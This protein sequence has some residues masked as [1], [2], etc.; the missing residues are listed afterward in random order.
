MRFL[1]RNVFSMHGKT[2]AEWFTPEKLASEEDIK[3]LTHDLQLV[4]EPFLL[5]RE[6]DVAIKDLPIKKELVLYCG[7][8]L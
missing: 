8:P 3:Q 1:N 7:S 6:K 5:R 2:F 4:I